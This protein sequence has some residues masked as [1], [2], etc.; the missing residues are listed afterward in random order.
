M[1]RDNRE[2]L[3]VGGLVRSAGWIRRTRAASEGCA[4]SSSRNVTRS[5]ATETRHQLNRDTKIGLSVASVVAVG[6]FLLLPVLVCPPTGAPKVQSS[7]QEIC[8]AVQ[9]WQTTHGTTK[10]P[11]VQALVG[12][13]ILSQGADLDP[14]RTRF[15]LRCEGT[16][17]AVTSAGPDTRFGTQDD[18]VVFAPNT[19]PSKRSRWSCSRP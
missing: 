13:K 17:I 9:V 8:L 10:C 11:A 5:R 12:E 16:G 6:S 1:Q 4:W 15:R 2:P 14:W 3:S 7:A 19:P 18:T